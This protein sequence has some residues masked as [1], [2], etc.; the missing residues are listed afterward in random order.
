MEVFP[1]GRGTRDLFVGQL[2]VKSHTTNAEKY[3]VEVWLKPEVCYCAQE[4]AERAENDEEWTKRAPLKFSF[5]QRYQCI[6]REGNTQGHVRQRP[7]EES[8]S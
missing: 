7:P 1:R 8:D 6:S 5:F 3:A 4:C 2:R